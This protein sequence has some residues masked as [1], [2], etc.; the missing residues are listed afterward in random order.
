MANI[1][2]NDRDLQEYLRDRQKPVVESID[3]LKREALLV[4]DTGLLCEE[5]VAKN[6]IAPIR[7]VEAGITW[8]KDDTTINQGAANPTPAIRVCF[9]VPFEGAVELFR[10]LPPETNLRDRV[11]ADIYGT[12]GEI[13]LTYEH[14]AADPSEFRTRFE[15][16]LAYIK[17]KVANINVA[18]E[19]H[20][21][22]L[23]GIIRERIL[24]RANLL[25][26]RDWEKELGFPRKQPGAT[27]GHKPR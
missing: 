21:E 26:E 5:L 7:L 6:S 1:L 2:F 9:Y 15:R 24:A 16:D 27:K 19:K 13:S 18:V 25:Q 3:R 12:S 8:D 10:C 4:E 22:S 20:N 17:P 23:R 14:T 11:A